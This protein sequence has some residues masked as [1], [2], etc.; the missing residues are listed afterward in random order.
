MCSSASRGSRISARID[1]AEMTTASGPAMG[2]V[3]DV[4]GSPAIENSGTIRARRGRVTLGAGDALSLAI[5]NTGRIEASG[6]EVTLTAQAGSVHNTGTISTNVSAGQA[7]WVT[8]QAP[9][10]VNDG[11]VTADA[12]NGRA[13]RVEL[14]S[15]NQ[16]T[17]GAGSVTSAAGG[18]G[19]AHGGEV[20]VHSYQ[21]DTTMERGSVVDLSGGAR[22]GHGGTGEVSAKN[23]LGLQGE[24]K[25]DTVDGFANA[26]ILLDP[27]NIRVVDGPEGDI[28]GDQYIDPSSIEGFAGDVSLLADN[29]ISIGSDINKA[30]GGLSLTAGNDIRFEYVEPMDGGDAAG[31]LFELFI[32]ADSLDFN[33]GHSI[34]DNALLGTTLTATTGD[35]NLVGA[36]GGVDFGLAGVANGRSVHITQADSRYFR[37]SGVSGLLANPENTHLTIDVTNGSLIMGGDFGGMV[38]DQL[39]GS[40]DISASDLVRFEDSIVSGGAVRVDAGDDIQFGFLP[41]HPGYPDFDLSITG[42]Q[43]DMVAGHS[44][45]DNVILGTH[46]TATNLGDINLEGTTG[47]VQFGLA[48]VDPN[49]F[50]RITQAVDKYV[51]AGPFGFIDTPETTNL[52]VTITDGWLIFGGDFGGMTGAQSILSVDGFAN[53]FVR[54]EDD[55]TIGDFAKFRANDNVEFDGFVHAQ[56]LVDAHAGLDG[57]GQVLFISPGQS[58]AGQTIALRAGNDSGLAMANID[59]RTNDPMFFGPGLG[60]TRPDT[61][62]FEQDAGVPSIALPLVSQFGGSDDRDELLHHL[63]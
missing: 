48:S 38:G 3:T 16:T 39:V 8:V 45:V 20:L 5:R 57:T 7:G 29:D 56:N 36:T 46:L 12:D 62:I 23:S 9:T 2:A 50:V 6:G 15:T 58:L 37:T 24:L 22:G 44:I 47:D 27:T 19:V 51:G 54:V 41:D 55:L 31:L 61:F 32:T 1:G 18:R 33:A 52:E 17:L 63:E 25:G 14:T 11:S 43:I 10:V 53:E 40:L 60:G 34:V 30:N 59:A 21:G 4:S 28:G 26:K 42:T 13:G 49:R 35:I